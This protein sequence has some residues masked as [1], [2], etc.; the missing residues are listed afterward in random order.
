MLQIILISAGALAVILIAILLIRKK[1]TPADKELE[2]VV[3]KV[4]ESLKDDLQDSATKLIQEFLWYTVY[5]PDKKPEEQSPYNRQQRRR[6]KRHYE[7]F[8]WKWIDIPEEAQN[9]EMIVR[10]L[11]S[12]KYE[13]RVVRRYVGLMKDESKK[14]GKDE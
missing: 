12:T 13:T 3:A 11:V 5:D 2:K 8:L 9:V 14:G 1:K 7:K 10:Y 4:T 6:I